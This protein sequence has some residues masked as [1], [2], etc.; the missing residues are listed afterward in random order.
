MKDLEMFDN[1]IRVDEDKFICLNDLHR[2]SGGDPKKRPTDFLRNKNTKSFITALNSKVE[3]STIKIIRGGENSGTWGHKL[4]CYK[5][6]GFIDADFE[7]GVYTILDKYFSGE[8]TP[9]NFN[10]RLQD[11]ARR[12]LSCDN[13]GSFHGRGLAM[14]KRD[15]NEIHNEGEKLMDEIQIKINFTQ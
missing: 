13:K 1:R 10:D 9:K 3:I 12:A 7:V 11:W 14:H 15:K 4:V 5:Y 2:A 8:L 6:A